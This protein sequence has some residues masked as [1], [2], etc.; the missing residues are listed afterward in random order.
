MII[1]YYHDENLLSRQ[2]V[3]LYEHVFD[4]HTRTDVRVQV[5]ALVVMN[6]LIESVPY[7][8][9]IDDGSF[10]VPVRAICASRPPIDCI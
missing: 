8:S 5:F 1:A 7:C 9:P 2:N 4:Y 6:P 3:R 10:A